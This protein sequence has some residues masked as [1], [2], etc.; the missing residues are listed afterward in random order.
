M[1]C[2]QCGH[3]CASGPCKFCARPRRTQPCESNECAYCFA[4]TLASNDKAIRVWNDPEWS[5]RRVWKT[6]SRLIRVACDEC[7][8]KTRTQALRIPSVRCA[9]CVNPNERA[10]YEFLKEHFDMVEHQVADGDYRYDFLVDNKIVVEVDG[11]QHFRPV[12]GWKTG[13]EQFSRDLQKEEHIVASGRGVVRILQESVKNDDFDWREFVLANTN[14]ATLGSVITPNLPQYKKG[15]Y[16][17]IRVAS[18]F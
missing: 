11:P 8:L 4:N 13:V 15:V 7:G 9:L 10:V 6:S 12:R 17:R 14:A 1:S 2:D 16:A 5:P 3:E 18:F